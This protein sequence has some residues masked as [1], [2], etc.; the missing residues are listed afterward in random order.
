[1]EVTTFIA[2]AVKFDRYDDEA[3]MHPENISSKGLCAYILS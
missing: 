3:V 2:D 1:M